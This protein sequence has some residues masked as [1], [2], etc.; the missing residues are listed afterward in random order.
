MKQTLLPGAHKKKSFKAIAFALFLIFCSVLNAQD[1]IV[2][3]I[4]SANAN[5]GDTIVFPVRVINFFDVASIS[6]KINY[7]PAV[8]TYLDYKNVNPDLGG[9]LLA[10]NIDGTFIVSWFNVTSGVTLPDGILYEIVFIYNGGSCCLE[11]NLSSQENCQYSNL[12]ATIIP[13]LWKNGCISTI[14]ILPFS[15]VQH[16]INIFPNPSDGNFKCQISNFKKQLE[17]QIINIHGQEIL[18]DKF[19]I[20]SSLYNKVIDL[21]MWPKGI[22]FI[23]FRSKNIVKTERLVIR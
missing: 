3:S 23:T 4:D 14:G 22:Y 13:A 5:I 6:H 20:N 12:A 9:F 18:K 16:Q 1:T 2:T 11:W 15:H 7:N 19:E 17:M 10:N 8:L 21:S